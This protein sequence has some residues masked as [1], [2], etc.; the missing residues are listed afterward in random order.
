MYRLLILLFLLFY[1]ENTHAQNDVPHIRFEA[2][3]NQVLG[4]SVVPH[5]PWQVKFPW[6]EL[7]N[8]E[9]ESLAVKLLA[10]GQTDWIKVVTRDA[11]A[12]DWNEIDF[13]F[14][15]RLLVPKIISDNEA[16]LRIENPQKAFEI[17]AY[18]KD[19]PIARMRTHLC[20]PLQKKVIL[21]PLTSQKIDEKGLQVE[22]NRIYGQANMSWT[23]Q[24]EKPFQNKIFN[25]ETVFGQVE[26]ELERYTGQMRLLR[27]QYFA[28]FP[29][30]DKKA[31]YVFVIPFFSDSSRLGYMVP[32]KSMGFVPYQ[33]RKK[34]LAIQLARCLATG[35]GGLTPSWA[36]G[37]KMGT[38]FNLMDT[39]GGT[40]LQ[41]F[42]I[43]KLQNPNFYF[44]TRDAYEFVRSG[45]GTVAY[46]FWE[47]DKDGNIL[48]NKNSFSST[49]R[50]PFKKNFL[51]FRFNFRNPLM[52]PLFRIGPYYISGL[53]FLFVGMVVFLVFY[54]RKKTK[55]F[56]VKKGWRT[57]FR[58]LFFWMKLSL[59]VFL[60]HLSFT[61]GNALLDQFTLLSGPL[62]ELSGN[63][64]AEAKDL[65]FTNVD[66]RKQS[67][68]TM[69]SEV[70]TH[71]GKNWQFSRLKK[72]LYFET[73]LSKKG[74]K[75]LKFKTSSDTLIV[76]AENFKAVA[77]NHYIV[78]SVRDAAGKIIQQDVFDYTN[79]KLTNFAQRENPPRRILL[80]VN[81]YRPTSSGQSFSE[82]FQGIMEKG[83]E[84]PN[85]TN[86][87]YSFDRY[88]YWQPWGEINLQFQNRINP[89]VTLYADGHFS[90]A[91]S[92][93]NSLLHFSRVA[94]VYPKRCKNKKK[95]H[96]YRIKNDTYTRFIAPKQ[97]TKKLIN[98]PANQKG[99]DY[100]KQK[101]K[102][103]GMN[104][105]QE[106]NLFPGISSNDTL[107]VVAHSMGFAYA[108]GLIEVLRGKIHFGGYYII[109]PENAQSGKVR[110]SEWQ[111]IW[112]YGSRFNLKGSD[113]PCLQDGVAPQSSAKNLRSSRRVFIPEELYTRKGFFDS[114]F[115]GY[116][117]WILKLQE[118]DP[119]YI[120]QR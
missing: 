33:V 105:L 113:A 101:G 19:Q 88:D 92:D 103:A 2:H 65:L 120:R 34:K 8:G 11:E 30:I 94:Q 74:P 108:Q 116:Y 53:N 25:S 51:S 58:R 77:S 46:Y 16:L 64:Y 69:S 5:N 99:F 86:Y 85:S 106:L 60:I 61:W 52:R 3:E 40:R 49:I 50:R 28:T 89:S 75:K 76:R 20:K 57:F 9:K 24:V 111:E 42:Q 6:I 38:S 104:V 87:V 82:G 43:E 119:G 45:N 62:P 12:V 83:F 70:L 35:V 97:K 1:V 107:Y 110:P 95:H 81:G 90:V 59:G 91:T 114:H 112:Q 102:I 41:F 55:Q 109:A 63:N 21:V 13:Y 32:Y 37:P 93:Y 68:Y 118:N 17:G 31:F 84:Y 44:S 80:F 47:E 115:I 73:Q 39:T 67:A 4:F 26:G 15:D 23:V 48:Q 79:K 72:V 36:D 54:G 27:D 71:Q 100:R 18:Y 96:C 14:G 22:L 117:D 7:E 56:W 66:F 10:Q 78:H 29:N 98:L